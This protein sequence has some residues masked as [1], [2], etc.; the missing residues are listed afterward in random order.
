MNLE[1]LENQ[2]CT[3]REIKEARTRNLAEYLQSGTRQDSQLKKRKSTVLSTP[4]SKNVRQ[5]PYTL[6]GK[7]GKNTS[8]ATR[9]PR[10]IHKSSHSNSSDSTSVPIDTE[11]NVLFR[12]FVKSLPSNLSARQKRCTL[13]LH[14][15]QRALQSAEKL[16]I[17]NSKDDV[18][19]NT[20]A[21]PRIDVKAPKIEIQPSKPKA[22]GKIIKKGNKRKRSALL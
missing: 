21:I 6:P 2:P 5:E 13:I 1:I 7:S 10:T 11:Q 17:K 16:L 4:P 9:K 20:A 15:T 22:K 8:K 14:M 3:D 19:P 12:E 18:M